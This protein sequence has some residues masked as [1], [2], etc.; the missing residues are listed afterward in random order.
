MSGVSL[1]RTPGRKTRFKACGEVP[2]FVVERFF[3]QNRCFLPETHRGHCRVTV[4]QKRRKKM[5]KFKKKF[6]FLKM[7][8]GGPGPCQAA[9]TVF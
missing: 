3:A 4:G 2:L 6:K 5:Q 1:V 8:N 7:V 9:R